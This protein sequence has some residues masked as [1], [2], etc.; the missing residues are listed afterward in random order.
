MGE[1]NEN[2]NIGT[3]KADM[4]LNHKNESLF[5]QFITYPVLVNTLFL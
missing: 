4:L 3:K 5:N 2:I 1:I